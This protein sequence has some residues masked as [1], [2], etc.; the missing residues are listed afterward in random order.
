V[1]E[2]S[3]HGVA[4][5]SV[6]SRGDGDR[7]G[8]VRRD[9]LDLHALDGVGEARA[10]GVPGLED[11]G[12][13]LLVPGRREPEVDEPGAGDLGALHE[14]MPSCLLRQLIRDLPR[15]LL[16]LRGELERRVRREVAVLG[17]R[18]PF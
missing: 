2:E 5:R 1:L 17:A 6:P 16:P 11:L 18:R 15:R 3:G 10:V 7:A 9:H 8:R 4:V 13:R 14:L 12:E